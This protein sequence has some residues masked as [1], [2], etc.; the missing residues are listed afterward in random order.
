MIKWKE[1]TGYSKTDW[2][3]ETRQYMNKKQ[4]KKKQMRN[5]TE[6]NITERQASVK[7]TLITFVGM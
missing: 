1:N 5:R 3:A 2:Q 6:W 4:K 7:L